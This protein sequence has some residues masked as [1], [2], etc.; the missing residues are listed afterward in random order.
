M[1]KAVLFDLDGVIV[2]T[3]SDHFRAWK[4][5][6]QELEIHIDEAFNERLKGI[7]R[8]ASLEIILEYGKRE[9]EFTKEEKKVLSKRKN[10]RYLNLIT[11]LGPSDIFPGILELLEELEKEDILAVITSGSRNASKVLKY[12]QL[13]DAFHSVVNLEEVEQGKPHPDI[14]LKGAELAGTAAFECV[15]IEDAPNG[16]DAIQRAGMCAIGIG[17]PDILSQADAVYQ[18]TKDLTLDSLNQVYER[19][20]VSK[21]LV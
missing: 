12:L 1:I 11:R 7:G 8:Q 3:A 10:E 6:A 13:Q 15:A 9:K 18:D 4:S 21:G 5:L 19:W 20:R 2:D 16:I 14:F 17:D